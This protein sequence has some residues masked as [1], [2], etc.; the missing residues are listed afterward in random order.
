MRPLLLALLLLPSLAFAQQP[1]Y[2]QILVPF[3]SVSLEVPGAR[4]HA[5]LW[6]RNDT[7]QQVNLF[8]ERCF[9]I[10]LEAP[11]T[12]KILVPAQRTVRLDL[13]SGFSPQRPGVF[14]Y[15]RS[16]LKDDIQFS[17]RVRDA[18]RGADQIGTEIPIARPSDLETTKATLINVPLLPTG[19]VDLRI[20]MF[21]APHARFTVRLFAE[22]SGDRLAERQYQW[23]GVT[24][25]PVPA[26]MPVVV[27][28]SSIF[29]AWIVDQVRVVIESDAGVR[30]WPLLT[31]T[32]RRNN[33]ITVV[34]PQ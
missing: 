7:A 6:V 24:D 19:K 21:D 16:D 25:A 5:D 18:D 27:D 30:F 11:C 15:V 10:G 33:Q 14:L 17:L 12:T 8:P 20:Y 32:N 28:A 22:P 23:I 26:V 1:Q 34:R 2:E 9:F 13:L 29:R 4:W 31:I 3:D